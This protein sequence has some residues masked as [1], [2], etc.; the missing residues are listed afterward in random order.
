MIVSA[1]KSRNET[2][3]YLNNENRV[4]GEHG[5]HLGEVSELDPGQSGALTVTLKPRLYLLYCNIPMHYMDGMW[6]ILDVKKWGPGRFGHQVR[7]PRRN[8]SEGRGP[9][10][11]FRSI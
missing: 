2:M 3:P 6:T 4:D 11:K 5:S 9:F 1:I 10:C 8:S 7:A